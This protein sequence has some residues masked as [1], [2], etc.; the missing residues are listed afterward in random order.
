MLGNSVEDFANYA[1]ENFKGDLVEIGLGYG[2]TTKLLLPVAKEHEREL[3]GIDPFESGWDN[4]PK[5]YQYE[6]D[7]FLKNMGGEIDKSLIIVKSNSLSSEAEKHCSCRLAFAFIDGLQYK[8][9]ILSDLRIVA[10]A[11]V[12]VLDDYDRDYF[13]SEVPT[14]IR[15]YM[16]QNPH[17]ELIDKGKWAVII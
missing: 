7:K 10:H 16:K 14:A 2:D 8:G 6:Y 15:T 12:I 11:K 17:R 5:S 1:C 9:A 3:I 4:M 13:Y